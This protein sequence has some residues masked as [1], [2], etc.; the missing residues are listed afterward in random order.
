MLFALHSAPWIQTS[1]SLSTGLL[2]MLWRMWWIHFLTLK[3]PSSGD[4]DPWATS[5]INDKSRKHTF[6]PAIFPS[7]TWQCSSVSVAD[8]RLSCQLGPSSSWSQ[9]IVS[10]KLSLLAAS[11][12]NL[13]PFEMPCLGLLSSP[14]LSFVFLSGSVQAVTVTLRL[15]VSCFF[16]MELW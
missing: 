10:F 2:R 3:T 6:E 9:W 1:L 15:L 14:L 12:S 5:W 7:L 16:A 4:L 11:S 13:I 8:A